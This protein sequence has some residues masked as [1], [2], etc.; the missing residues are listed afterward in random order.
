MA[1]PPNSVAIASALPTN[2]FGSAFGLAA[3]QPSHAL[4]SGH[5]QPVVPIPHAP[6]I[7]GSNLLDLRDGVQPIPTPAP[8]GRRIQAWLNQFDLTNPVSWW[9]RQIETL[10]FGRR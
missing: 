2:Y 10:N 7:G 3:T 1:G 8:Q 5:V 6:K 4:F 9:K